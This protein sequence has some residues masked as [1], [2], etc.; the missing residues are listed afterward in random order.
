[1]KPQYILHLIFTLFSINTAFASADLS[2]FITSRDL[3]S[4]DSGSNI[5]LR[6]NRNSNVNVYGLYVRQYAYVATSAT[7]CSGATSIFTGNITAGAMVTPTV[8]NAGKSAIVGGN[9]LYNMILGAIYYENI[10]IPAFPPGCALPGC[11]WGTD[12]T[13]YKW[14][15]YLGALSPVSNSP[16]YNANVPPNTEAASGAGYDYN[17]ITSYAYLGPIS[18]DDQT[19]SCSVANNQTQSFS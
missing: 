11:T 13:K 5:Y 12:T 4:S 3:L 8:I 7:T 10:I 15:I 1:M 18:C 6:N 9:Y 14:C 2:S 16:S 19:L 17:L